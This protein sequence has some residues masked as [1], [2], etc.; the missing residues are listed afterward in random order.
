MPIPFDYMQFSLGVYN[1]SVQNKIGNPTGWDLNNWQPDKSS[2][3][4]AGYYFSSQ[5]NEMVISYTG[6]ND[7]ADVVNWFIGFGLP[8]QQIFD[9]VDYYFACKAAHPTANITFTGH[10]LGGGL[11]SLMAVYFNKQATVFDEAPFQLAAVNPLVSDAVGAYM[12]AK[13]YVDSSFAD[14]LLSAGALALTREA[15]VTHYYVEGEALGYPRFPFDTLVG[16][17]Y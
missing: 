1:A 17:E 13:G 14:Y 7:A 6:T 3:F 9:A 12:I 4:S 2:G 8:M 5:T 10:S 16:Q 11:A 15:N